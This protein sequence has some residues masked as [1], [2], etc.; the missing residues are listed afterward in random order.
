MKDFFK[1][2]FANIVALFLYTMVFFFLAVGFVGVVS[3]LGSGNQKIIIK[4][5][6]V[7]HLNFKSDIVE[8]A[9]NNG[10]DL[11]SLLGDMQ[12]SVGL[13]EILKS[14][15]NAK[16]DA[17]I[18]GIFIENDDIPAGIATVD[19]IRDAILDFKL[20][21]KFV[22]A[23]GDNLSQTSYYLA[24]AADKVSLNPLGE[25]I[26]KGLRS[27]VS[28][29]KGALEKLGV[30]VQVFRHG[31]FKSAVEPYLL[32]RMSDENRMQYQVMLSAMWN[33][34]V[35]AVSESRKIDNGRLNQI[36]DGCLA[37][38]PDDAL[39][40]GLVDGIM[41]RSDA[42]DDFAT[43]LGIDDAKKM[44]FVSVK[45]YAKSKTELQ[46]GKPKVAVIYASGE[47]VRA[48][49]NYSADAEITPD[50]YLEALKT[51]RE[52]S[53]IK[54][55]VLR[56]NSPGGDAQVSDAIWRE[57]ELTKQVKPVVVSMGDYAAS[58][59]YYISCPASYI[60]ANEFTLTGSI[61]VFGLSLNLQKLMEDK[62]GITTDVVKT[63]KL[64]DMG[65]STR[66]ATPAEREI[67][68]RNVES[69][70]E[71]F[72]NRVSNG[73]NLAPESVDSIGQGRVWCAVDAL[74][75]GLIDSFGGITKA[76]KIASDMAG[77]DDYSIVDFPKQED[78]FESVLKSLTED[79]YARK[80]NMEL[81]NY[82][83]SAKYIRSL[84][85]SQGVQARMENTIYIY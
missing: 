41:Y 78:P 77:L 17:N 44:N 47:I 51:V 26:F 80:M 79:V 9:S 35:S 25:L 30:E 49:S 73:R 84:I 57:V 69:V 64:S 67:I 20:S 42:V 75:I 4:P 29:Y 55:V 52:D 81:G 71:T 46:F 76:M 14:I 58:G 40:A 50:A 11:S 85:E 48:T 39:S 38:M 19:E 22:Y 2:V 37:Q 6:S 53:T 59:G 5:N 27:E 65:S 16:D 15:A 43:C 24:S 68:Q 36:A 63:N 18:K 61:G 23:Y 7:L 12:P 13:D 60:V 56:V 74:R 1:N 21:G 62:L 10:I 34:Y 82:A 70:Y 3:A 83:K 8:R 66:K 45:K 33:K 31:K 72:V 54:A 32:S 28:F